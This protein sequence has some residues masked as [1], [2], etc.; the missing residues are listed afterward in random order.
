MESR[1][2]FFVAHMFQKK[3]HSR[4][5]NWVVLILTPFPGCNQSSLS[6]P[7]LEDTPQETKM[8]MEIQPFEDVSPIFFPLTC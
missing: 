2:V 3:L 1:R 6:P 4:H 8:T 7:E 5:T